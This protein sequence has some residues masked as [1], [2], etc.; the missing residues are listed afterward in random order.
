[1]STRSSS[2]YVIPTALAMYYFFLIQ[3]VS[4]WR[5]HPQAASVYEETEKRLL[6]RQ[7]GSA[8]SRG[9]RV[10]K[11]TYAASSHAARTALTTENEWKK[12]TPG[13][14][15]GGLTPNNVRP[16]NLDSQLD[17]LRSGL[18]RSPDFASPLRRRLTQASGGNRHQCVWNRS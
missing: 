15:R 13:T 7:F 14:R 3:T 12:R 9:V 8:L 16:R 10:A 1:M 11:A 6:S 18:L 5:R 2:H 17:A 4:V